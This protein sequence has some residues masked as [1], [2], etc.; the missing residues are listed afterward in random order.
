MW[1]WWI[2]FATV[3]PFVCTSVVNFVIVVDFWAFP[4]FIFLCDT[5]INNF[6]LSFFFFFTCVVNFVAVP[7]FWVFHTFL[8]VCV[9]RVYVPFFLT[10][11][12]AS[13][14]D[15][16]FPPFSSPYIPKQPPFHSV[17]PNYFCTRD[18][19]VRTP[20]RTQ[21]PPSPLHF[22]LTFIHVFFLEE[23]EWRTYII[24]DSVWFNEATQYYGEYDKTCH[25]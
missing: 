4:I 10:P 13:M 20:E 5:I 11:F 1:C 24:A 9:M 12:F 16:F 7:Y 19:F 17:L 3:S 14:V 21:P 23:R 2:L 15:F 22:C 8:C 18:P 25:R 6:C